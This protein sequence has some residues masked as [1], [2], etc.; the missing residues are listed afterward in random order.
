MS[1]R[2]QSVS[3]RGLLLYVGGVAV[4]LGGGLL[5]VWRMGSGPR[6]G[7]SGGFR[8]LLLV[9][10]D[11][12]RADHIGCYGYSKGA[13]PNIDQMARQGVMFSRCITVAPI[14]LPSHASILTGL[15]PQHHGARNNGT[16]YLPEE[17]PTLAEQL[18]G[19]GFATG[20]V[21]SSFVLDSRFGLDQGFHAYDDDLSNAEKSPLFMFRETKAYDTADRAIRWLQDR[22]VERWFLWVHFFDPH[23]NYQAPDVFAAKCPES[24]YDGEVA[25]AD[26]GLGQVLEALRRS[27]EL[28]ET[29]VV[30]TSDHGESLGEHGEST[31]SIFVYDA[32]TRVP[33]VLMHPSLVQGK[34]VPQ[35]VSSV[36]ITPTLLDLL[37]VKVKPWFDG[38]SLKR[39]MLRPAAQLEPR[40]VY[41]EAMTPWYNHGWSDMRAVRDDRGRF[42]RAPRP[43]LYDLFRDG[44]ELDNLY[45]A[46]PTLAEPF[47]GMLDEFLQGTEA[48]VRGDDIRSMDPDAREALAALGYVWSSEDEDKEVPIERRADPKD[49]VHLWERSQLA[50]DL[51]RNGQYEEAEI[52][53]RAVLAED[54]LSVITRS[55]FAT[56]LIRLAREE[57]ALEFLLES[58]AIPGVRTSTYLRTAGLERTLGRLEWREHLEQAKQHDPRDPMPCVREGDWAQEDGDPD[59]A[60]AAYQ[61]ALEL[62]ERCASAWVG[63]GNTEHRRG[64]DTESEAA[65]RKAVE[66]DPIAFEG[67]YNL[68]VVVEATGRPT[69]AIRN[70]QKAQALQPNHVLTLVNL[71]NLFMRADRP[72]EA[73]THF[74]AALAADPDDFVANVNYGL[75][76]MKSGRHGLSIEVFGKASELEPERPEPVL[77]RMNARYFEGDLQGALTDAERLLTLQPDSLPGLLTAASSQTALGDAEGAAQRLRRAL[78]LDRQHVE[79]RAGQDARLREALDVLPD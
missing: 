42:I 39:V 36:D 38:R 14:T 4:L 78:E 41:S 57:E 12:V 6:T 72:G 63:I 75:H 60:I 24:P 2:V 55:A 37:A 8:N 65:L 31:H 54:P 48:D 29:L 53:L 25:Y 69:E 76:L 73:E 46:N 5:L 10:I 71:G 61:T 47:E 74:R 43:E 66:A 62:D 7:E 22:G 11:T 50:N 52:A 68:G 28:A 77:H 58:L 33:L 30:L 18:D 67:W 26:A 32:T 35:V 23:A 40:P 9:T 45:P 20:A 49:K 17:V 79:S 13:T 56:V 64:N 21:I 34:R 19:A 16:H 1:S 27:E 3:R 59:A 70:Y 51:L 15:Y 44:R